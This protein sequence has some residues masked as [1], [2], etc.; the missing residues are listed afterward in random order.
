M[1]RSS[2][3]RR[4]YLKSAWIFSRTMVLGL[5]V[6]L[7]LPHFQFADAWQVHEIAHPQEVKTQESSGYVGNQTCARCHASIF[8]SYERT[9]M[10]HA[11]GP[12][13]ENLSPADFVHRK[14]GVHY[15][16]YAEA[17][18]AWLSFERPG[19]TSATGNRELLY[20][21][22]S[23]RRGR[24]YLFIVDG[25]V[26]ES[27]VNWYADRHQWDM[28]P[29]YDKVREIPLNL[30]AYPECLRCHTSGMRQPLNGTENQYP[31]PLFTQDGVGC[32]RCHG[33]GESHI[34]EKNSSTIVNPVKLP[35]ALRDSICMQCHLEGSV[36][37]ERAGRR[38]FDFRPGDLLDDYVRHYVLT[39]DQ[40]SGLGANG[41]FEALAQSACKK[42]SGDAM[43][44]MSC[45]DP[46][47]SP[48]KA[49]RA[50]YYREKCL[51]CHGPAFGAKHHPQQIDCASCHMP[52]S[53][54]TDIAHTEVTDHRIRCR[55][56][57]SPD[58]LLDV[59]ARPSSNLLL[60]P[61]STDKDKDK[62]EKV[63][64]V[65]DRALAWQSVAE[66]GDPHA[67]E[68]AASLLRQAIKQSPDDPAVLSAIAY[69]ELN[70]GDLDHARSLYEHALALSPDLI[71]AAVNLGVL[72]AKT[73]NLK[74]AVELWKKAFERAPGKSAIGM[75]LSR[76]FCQAGQI[77]EARVFVSRVL[78]FNPDLSEA[79]E[80]Q[81]GLD[82]D[83]PRCGP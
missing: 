19:D 66:N 14:S 42:K 57:L 17:G 73:G 44:C 24:S 65:R 46:H 71:D 31:S 25:F 5:T 32:E 16:I 11:S 28:A 51:A 27:P 29:A 13:T 67:I 37:V 48:S 26:F 38:V 23:G 59:S 64:D 39:G 83:P 45:H 79:R 7:S 10:A 9:P 36:S 62:D 81:R 40:R 76:A 21:I 75:N 35:P 18:A 34:K 30:P 70:Q 3:D 68:Q 78:H 49:E 72:E 53:L 55:P 58:V 6:F 20:S 43:S 15:R 54:S 22:G 77:R 60:F 56:E 63:A 4:G 50:S 74:R 8:E 80:F 47:Y 41:Q 82:A 52:S 12:A 33:P 2:L 61:E 1:A 69:V